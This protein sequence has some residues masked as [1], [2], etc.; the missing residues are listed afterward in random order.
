MEILEHHSGSDVHVHGLP[1]TA[2]KTES[3]AGVEIKWYDETMYWIH[4]TPFNTLE[5]ARAFAK[6]IHGI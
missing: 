3:H 6:D 5:D 1:E 2:I 4:T